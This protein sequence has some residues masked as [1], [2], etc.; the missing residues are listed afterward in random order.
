MQLGITHILTVAE[1]LQPR[2]PHSFFYHVINVGDNSF[3]DD[4]AQHL[5]TCARFID[6]GR[7]YGGVLV[8]C[9]SGVSRSVSAVCGYLMEYEKLSLEKAI[10]L[11]RKAR[12][13]A[14]PNPG[15][16][17]QLTSYEKICNIK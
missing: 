1:E 9:A 3:L 6:Q 2:Y 11:I 15:F 5:P 14:K 8:H 4:I 7:K 16:W 17:E 12:P 10:S 13:I